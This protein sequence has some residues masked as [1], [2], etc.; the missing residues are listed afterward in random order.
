MKLRNLIPS[1]VA[2][3]LMAACG[4][5]GGI[6]G[7]GMQETGTMRLHLTDA[8]ACGY[9]A[10]NVTVQKVRVN[11]DPAAGEADAGWQEIVLAPARRVDLLTLTNGVLMELGQADLPAGRYTQ[12]R[13][14]LAEND[15]ANPLA[16]SVVPSGGA[17]VALTTPSAQQS[18]LKIDV[19][20]EVPAGQEADFVLDF[21][22]CKSVV[23]RGNSGQYNLKPVLSVSPLLADAGLRVTGYVDPAIALATTQVSV[24]QGGVPVKA[25]TPDPLT[26]RF[27]LYPLP[28]G[29]YDLV[30]SAAGRATAVIAGVPV[31]SG[32]PT[33]INVS[34]AG[35]LPPPLALPLR[36]VAG[37]LTPATGTLRAL[38]TLTAGPTVEVAWAAVDPV[39]GEFGFSLNS[40]PPVRSLWTGT[41]F[42]PFSADAAAAAHYTLQAAAGAVTKN[43]PVDTS[44]P[45]PALDI[46]VP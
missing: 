1:A 27:V 45:V 19:G 20:L 8:P 35:L 2:T 3:I 21:D 38:Q 44:V 46:T 34:G 7:T 13:L 22:A 28:A 43:V 32:V 29:N 15:A 31:A 23:R 25:T 33:A 39:S 11:R 41:G 24:Q 17:E 37:T 16:N 14:V 40:D 42:A 10:V 30:L 6:S 9:D 18:G 36:T 12:L 26:G 5:G 4:G